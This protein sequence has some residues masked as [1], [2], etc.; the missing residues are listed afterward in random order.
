[1]FNQKINQVISE[2]FNIKKVKN[3]KPYGRGLINSTYLV[4]FLE[5]SYIIQKVNEYVF[6]SPIG[7]MYN[8]GLVTNHIRKRVIYEGKNY[9]NAT[10][11]LIQTI[12][13][14]NFAIVDDEYWRCYT[15]I[16]GITYETT[17][18]VE[19]FYEAGLVVGE[20]QQLLKDFKVHLLT[21]NI[22]NFHNTPYRYLQLVEVLQKPNNPYISECVSEIFFIAFRKNKLDVITK[23]LDEGLIPRRVVHNDTKLNNIMFSKTTKKA[24]CLIDLDTVM[25]GSLVYDYGDALRMGASNAKEDETNLNK[26]T[27]NF[28]LVK[29][30]TKGFLEATH[31]LIT[32]EEIKYLI[33]GYHLITLELGMRF[34]TDYLNG[35]KYFA[36]NENEQKNRPKINLERARN[37][38]KLVTEIENNWHL[39]EDIIQDTLK[40]L[41]N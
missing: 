16:D 22:K 10:L 14:E 18:D 41:T 26:V 32:K 2:Y 12:N 5:T 17:K 40:N 19:I 6:S 27:I 28:E 11:T 36:L 33:H 31:D 30:F 38:L 13:G 15:W 23:A 39:L 7:V 24:L 21:D 8:I 20:F 37:Q 25:K 29:A 3:V 35:N 34:L 9:R 1:M 4:E